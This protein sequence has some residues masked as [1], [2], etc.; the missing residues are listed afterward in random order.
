MRFKCGLNVVL[1]GGGSCLVVRD[2][3]SLTTHF[4]PPI[5]GVFYT[6][7]WRMSSRNFRTTL[8]YVYFPACVIGYGGAI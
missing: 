8:F 2:F 4:Q 3:S 1:G 7:I 6:Q 5:V